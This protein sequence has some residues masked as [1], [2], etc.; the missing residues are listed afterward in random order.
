MQQRRGPEIR[1]WGRNPSISWP[2]RSL[3]KLS[4]TVALI[5]AIASCQV[6]NPEF[7]CVTED[8]CNAAGADGLRPCGAGQACRDTACVAKECDTSIDCTSSDAPT[9]INNLCVGGCE[10]DDDCV[11]IAG[12]ER[13]DAAASTCVGCVTDDQCPIDRAICDSEWSLHRGRRGLRHRWRN[14]LCDTVRGRHWDVCEDSTLRHAP[15][16]KFTS[17][18]DQARDSDT[19]RHLGHGHRHVRPRSIS[20]PG[21]KQHRVHVVQFAGLFVGF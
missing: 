17:Y 2:M 7:C 11:G 10:V 9:C 4:V 19:R 12:K 13:C 1:R 5:L 6:K 16:C 3:M 14:H 20:S 15:V 18:S 21:R 8:Q